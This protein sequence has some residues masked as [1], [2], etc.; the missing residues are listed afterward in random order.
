MTTEVEDFN[1]YN[2]AMIRSGT[3][4]VITTVFV[5]PSFSAKGFTFIK[6]EDGVIC[7]S[8]MYY[9]SETGLFYDD[10]AFTS[11]NGVSTEQDSEASS[12]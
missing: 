3:C 1:F 10:E 11:I 6:V 4:K 8:G 5:P 12:E 9:N 2:Y 7:E